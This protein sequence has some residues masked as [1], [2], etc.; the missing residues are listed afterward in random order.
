[1]TMN[2]QCLRGQRGRQ[3][4]VEKCLE[5][6]EEFRLTTERADQVMRQFILS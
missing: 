6:R 1:M 3:M 5:G 4:R 2:M